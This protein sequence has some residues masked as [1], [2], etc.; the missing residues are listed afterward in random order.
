[1]LGHECSTSLFPV[2]PKTSTTTKGKQRRRMGVSWY[3]VES[4]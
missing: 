1:M 3:K 2:T 4:R